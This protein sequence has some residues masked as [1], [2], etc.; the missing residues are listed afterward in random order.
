MKTHP[1]GIEGTDRAITRCTL[2]PH[3]LVLDLGCGTGSTVRHLRHTHGFH[4]W[5]ID[6]D[7]VRD[8]ESGGVIHARAE[9]LP[10]AG[11]CADAVLMECSFSLMQHPGAVLDECRRVLKPD[12][13]LIVSDMIARGEPARLNGC[14]GRIE[15]QETVL[16]RLERGGF[17]IEDVEDL[18]EDLIRQWGQMILDRNAERFYREIGADAA[19]LRRIRCG[20]CRITSRRRH[21]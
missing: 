14:L 11:A 15:R 1:G 12:G 2:P 3:A 6:S 7:P 10:F 4:A 8:G 17:S 18:T 20:Y 9:Q 16:T 5:G 13:I 21:A 19:M